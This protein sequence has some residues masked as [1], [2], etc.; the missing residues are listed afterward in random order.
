MDPE[1]G[2][3]EAAMARRG[4]REGL[5]EDP[6]Y[7]NLASARRWARRVCQADAL[8]WHPTGRAWAESRRAPAGTAVVAPAR[9]FFVRGRIK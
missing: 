3:V 6:G 9:D 1:A 4:A 5:R 7:S 2:K 8:S